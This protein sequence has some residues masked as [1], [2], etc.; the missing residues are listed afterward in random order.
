MARASKDPIF[1][2]TPQAFAQ[3]VLLP[4]ISI[5]HPYYKDSR[6]PKECEISEVFWAQRISAS[7]PM[8]ILKLNGKSFQGLLD[9]GADATIISSKFW[10][11]TWPPIS[12]A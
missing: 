2:S 3:L 4:K 10:P 1:I 9:S 5:N 8:L 7:C 12:R 11:A 6:E